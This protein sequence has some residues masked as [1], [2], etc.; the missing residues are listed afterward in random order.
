MRAQGLLGILVERRRTRLRP[1]PFCR[2][3][4]EATEAMRGSAGEPLGV[5]DQRRDVRGIE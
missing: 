4:G 5:V 3:N 1:N 2:L